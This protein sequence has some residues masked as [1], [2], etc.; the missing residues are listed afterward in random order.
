VRNALDSGNLAF[1]RQN[2]A[3]IKLTLRDAVAV[4]G[5]IAEE[6]PD[7][8]E[9]ALVRWIR[10]FAAEARDPQAGDYTAIVACFD[11]MPHDPDLAEYQLTELCAERGLS[12]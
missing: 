12:Q 6:E 11:A 4:C 7:N 3:Q 5:T 10:R 9:R 2:A 8:L 1:I